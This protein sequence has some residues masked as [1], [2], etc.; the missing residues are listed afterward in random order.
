M[1]ILSKLIFVQVTKSTLFVL[2]A[3]VALFAFFDL[4][5][6]SSS[7]G[8]NYGILDAFLLTGLVLPTRAYQVLPIAVLLGAIFTLS[9]LAATSQFTVMRVSGISPW[10]FCSKLLIPG[11]LFVVLAFVLGELL[12]PPANRMQKETKLDLSGSAFTGKGMKTG[13][14]VRDVLRGKD[15]KAESIRFVN[16]KSLKPGE[17]AYDW[18]IYVFNNSDQLTSLITAKEGVYN[19]QDGWVLKNV[20]EQH[21]PMLEKE[22]RGQTDE[23][24]VTRKMPKMVWG[25]SLDGNIF[26]LL[27]VKPENMS[28]MELN[29]YITYL[30]DNGQTYKTYETAFWSKFFYP[31][32][33]LVM[34]VLAMPFAYQSARAGGMA[35]KIFCG[36]MIGIV[37]YALN[38]IF[39]FMSALDNVPSFIS[40]LIPSVV[41]LFLATLAM[42]YV[43]RRV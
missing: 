36:I 37:Y 3:L 39:A 26:G 27:M 21:I 7:I 43:E 22:F 1:K 6:Q 31:F 24:V 11:V 5:G 35:I 38:N 15:G 28:L 41:M 42:W 12:A 17:A 9:R 10:T 19:A 20:T 18:E 14:W 13:I 30:K 40:A 29:N 32:A 8:R 2:L 34:L 23:K 33:I 16:V 25:K 4:I